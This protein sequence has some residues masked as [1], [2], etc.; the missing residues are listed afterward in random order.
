MVYDKRFGSFQKNVKKTFTGYYDV[1]T[2]DFR[3]HGK[4]GGFYTFTSNEE[5]R[6]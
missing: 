2:M 3:G 6:S 5:K 4:S 1:I